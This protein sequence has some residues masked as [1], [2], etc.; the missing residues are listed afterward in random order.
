MQQIVS[1]ALENYYKMYDGQR[2]QDFG[3]NSVNLNDQSNISLDL[4]L[5]QK[6]GGKEMFEFK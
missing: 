4:N 3:D 6:L 2:S 5:K 1:T